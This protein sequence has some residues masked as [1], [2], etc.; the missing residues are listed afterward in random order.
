MK[1][2]EID[3]LIGLEQRRFPKWGAHQ[4]PIKICP[5]CWSHSYTMSSWGFSLVQFSFIYLNS[6]TYN[7]CKL[8]KIYNYTTSTNTNLQHNIKYY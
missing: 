7:L 2:S 1:G 3:N 6:S 5:L 4:Q 8:T